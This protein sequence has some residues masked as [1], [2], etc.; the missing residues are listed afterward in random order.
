M[1]KDPL[2]EVYMYS[3]ANI[4]GDNRIMYNMQFIKAEDTLSCTYR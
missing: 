4:E 1:R 3:F 2:E